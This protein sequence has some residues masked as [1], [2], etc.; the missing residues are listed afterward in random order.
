MQTLFEC[1][2]AGVVEWDG[3]SSPKISFSFP[4]T[5]NEMLAFFLVNARLNQ[6]LSKQDW[7]LSFAGQVYAVPPFPC[8]EMCRIL[9]QLPSQFGYGP[10]LQRSSPSLSQGEEYSLSQLQW[11]H[12]ASGRVFSYAPFVGV[13]SS[14]KRCRKPHGVVVAS[15]EQL[16]VNFD[17]Y[18]RFMGNGDIAVMNK[19]GI[20]HSLG[21]QTAYMLQQYFKAHKASARV[22]Y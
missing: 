14:N 16:T 4:I 18:G 8:Q 11:V 6:L 9:A 2:N 5:S 3:L 12:L 21:Y 10:L 22:R 1:W 17:R 7:Q 13:R 20:C 19:M 15:C